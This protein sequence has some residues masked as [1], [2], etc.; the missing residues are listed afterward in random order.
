MTN[1]AVD[2]R[3]GLRLC[4]LVELLAGGQRGWRGQG[5]SQQQGSWAVP[6]SRSV[7]A[8]QPCHVARRL[9]Q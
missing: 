1:L 8:E 5:A 3:D 4:R 7:S 6:D 2:L 9:Q